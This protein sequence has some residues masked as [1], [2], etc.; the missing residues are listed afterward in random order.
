MNRLP[1]RSTTECEQHLQAFF[2]VHRSTIPK[3][4][5]AYHK[6]NPQSAIKR[7][8]SERILAFPMEDDEKY[9]WDTLSE[10][11]LLE[12]NPLQEGIHKRVEEFHKVLE[13]K[14]CVVLPY[15]SEFHLL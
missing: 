5:D 13:R 15:G 14:T 2:K 7:E 4:I 1:T 9:Y 6:K 10:I 8:T 12:G 3:A 11:F